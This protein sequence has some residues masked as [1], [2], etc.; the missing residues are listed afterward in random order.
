MTQT[1]LHHQTLER[2]RA[3][4]THRL[5]ERI[6]EHEAIEEMVAEIEAAG[7]DVLGGSPT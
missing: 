1:E 2:V 6:T 5:D 4:L 7:F 3:I